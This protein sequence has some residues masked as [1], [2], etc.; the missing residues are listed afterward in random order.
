MEEISKKE[1]LQETGISYGQLYRW[2]RERL[3]PEE[4]FIKRSALTGQE[5]FFPR[6]QILERVKAIV[7]M[8][9]DSSLEEIRQTFAAEGRVVLLREVK[10]S[11]TLCLL[12]DANERWYVAV[13]EGAELPSFAEG[14]T[15]IR[16]ETVDDFLA[17]GQ[18]N[19]KQNND[20][21]SDETGA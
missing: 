21:S 10:A 11:E 2:K 12:Q 18:K 14:S 19:S 1:L 4:W 17:L 5:T 9:E 6:A 13:T 3:I 7:E 20:V 15:V 8:K 16:T